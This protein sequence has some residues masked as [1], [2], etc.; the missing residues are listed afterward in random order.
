[1]ADEL[2]LGLTLRGSAAANL[3]AWRSHPPQWLTAAGY[4]PKDESY[5]SL[6]YEADV[7]GG[8]MRFLMW[9]Q[10]RTLYRITA[11][12][13][14][15]GPFATRLTLVGQAQ[16]GTREAILAWAELQAAR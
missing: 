7:M 10:A 2:N 4:A 3:A 14:D 12:F 5:E 15:D 8:G 16:D 13:R 6:V 9:G 11:T 1:V